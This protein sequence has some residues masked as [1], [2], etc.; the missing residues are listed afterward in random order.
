MRKLLLSTFAACLFANLNADAQVSFSENFDSYNS[1]DLIVNTV[2]STWSTWTGPY[3]ANQDAPVSSEQANS[4]ENSLLLESQ[5]TAGPIDVVM[6]FG[7]KFEFGTFDFSSAI[8][9]DAGKGAYW[10]FQAEVAIGTA[11]ALEFIFLGDGTYFLRSDGTIHMNGTYTQ[12]EWFDVSLN[13][14][15]LSNNWVFSINGE[16]QGAFSNSINSIASMNLYPFEENTGAKFFIDDIEV[17]YEPPTLLANDLA[18]T[19]VRL[20]LDI[21]LPGT[22]VDVEVTVFNTG[23]NTVESFDLNLSNGVDIYTDEITG[24]SLESFESTT[25]THSVSYEVLEGSQDVLA[26]VTNPNGAADDNTMNNSGAAS[27]KGVTPVGGRSVVV[28]ELTGTWCPWCPYGNIL[29]DRLKLGFG[30]HFVPVAIHFGDPMAYDEYDA[31]IGATFNGGSNSYPNIVVNRQES[32]HP[33]NGLPA[34]EAVLTTPSD[35]NI[36]F[37][38]IYDESTDQYLILIG[39][40]FNNDYSGADYKVH[41]Q[42]VENNVTGVIS[43]YAQSNN[44]SGQ[45]GDFDGWEALSNPVPAAQMSYQE[46]ARAYLSSFDGV[47]GVIPAEVEAG[48]TYA[49][50][51]DYTPG[52][53]DV[54]ELHVVSFITDASGQ[55]VHAS[56]ISLA[57]A[58][59]NGPLNA[60]NVLTAA[61]IDLTV[62]P[63][64]ATE[65]VSVQFMDSNSE[66]VQLELVDVNGKVVYT[67]AFDNTNNVINKAINT[68]Q[69]STGIYM[70]NIKLDNQL[71]SKKVNVIH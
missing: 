2:P 57:D 17:A 16:E 63:N 49:T 43:Q 32:M 22:T 52:A 10:N 54:N 4:G 71:I 12:G 47:A 15:M 38:A 5:G 9:V 1:G 67:N 34:V 21:C 40:S 55:I 66:K 59:A 51:F 11:W 19:N 18:A 33:I 64:P 31:Y 45:P 6:N 14:D 8:Y 35:G 42:I 69:L 23:L 41:A 7:E 13:A 26:S 53:V 3:T 48:A 46:V 62:Y 30:D 56:Q 60:D 68:T 28:E 20:P 61:D 39:S 65:F 50:S 36:E 58:V 44:L 37:G 29:L 70:L 25:F 24:I 27:I